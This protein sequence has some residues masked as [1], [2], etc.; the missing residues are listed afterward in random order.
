MTSSPNAP[1][2]ASRPPL[3]AGRRPGRPTVVSPEKRDQ[4]REMHANGHS[5][6]VIAR[7]FTVGRATVRRVL[8]PSA[9]AE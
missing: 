3:R 2:P 4:I 7:T 9:P 5:I 1:R 8:E 6:S